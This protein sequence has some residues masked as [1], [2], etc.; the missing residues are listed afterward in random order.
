MD[1]ILISFN[2]DGM[3]AGAAKLRLGLFLTLFG[4]L[5]DMAMA[6]QPATWPNIALP[7]LGGR[8]VWADRYLY[9]GWRIQ[10]N[11]LTGHARLLDPQDIRRCWGPYDACRAT[12][13]RIRTDR[14]LAPHGEHLVLLVHGLG[15]SRASFR[16]LE[17]A[18]KD[19]GYDVAGIGYPSTRRSL[20][21]NAETLEALLRDLSGVRRVSF[22]TH[23]LGGLLVR[24][25]LARDAVWRDR[26]AVEAVVMI[27][28]P[29][30]GSAMAD[31]LQYV[32]PINWLLWRG[33][34]DATSAH[35]GTLPVPDVP[36]GIVAAGRGS[37]GY[38]PLLEGDDDIIVRVAETRLDGAADW[39]RVRAPHAVVMNRSQTIAAVM[40]FLE[41]KR[42]SAP[43]PR[44]GR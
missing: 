7:T 35:A 39:V 37:I 23:S 15:R 2:K 27:A 11:V 14:G 21:D 32:P 43:A 41:H 29:S 17:R 10:E 31:V 1:T 16:G 9:A 8:Q 28:P 34:F 22:V 19:A 30:Q 13:E 42:F 3:S 26:I 12:F 25:L 18:L 38:N 33:L 36:F 40:S 24:E 6:N 5:S 20:A 44:A 4:L